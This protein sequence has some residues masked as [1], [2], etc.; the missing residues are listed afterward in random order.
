MGLYVLGQVT[1]AQW[2]QAKEAR[3]KLKKGMDGPK[4]P[5]TLISKPGKRA[6]KRRME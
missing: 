1:A 4:K 3:K 6:K 2:M 5:A